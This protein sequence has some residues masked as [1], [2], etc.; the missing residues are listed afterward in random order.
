MTEDETF[1][2]NRWDLGFLAL[3]LAAVSGFFWVMGGWEVTYPVLGVSILLFIVFIVYWYFYMTAAK[4]ATLKT[5]TLRL[6]EREIPYRD[7]VC[8]KFVNGEGERVLYVR[9]KDERTNVCVSN[10]QR[11]VD[12]LAEHMEAKGIRI[13]TKKGRFLKNIN[14]ITNLD[15]Q[16]KGGLW[17]KIKE[18]INLDLQ[19]KH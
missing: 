7:I 11:F 17:D 12:S 14:E 8:A 2:A 1:K 6:D 13:K 16:K 4:S 3:F 10:D 9:T 15:Q 5:D 19:K 18:I